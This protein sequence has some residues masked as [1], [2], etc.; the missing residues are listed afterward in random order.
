MGLWDSID[1]CLALNAAG[2]ANVT[3]WFDGLQMRFKF[4]YNC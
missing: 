4:R 2:E 1:S 3:I